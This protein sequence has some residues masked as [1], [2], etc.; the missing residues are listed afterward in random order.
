MMQSDADTDTEERNSDLDV[1][2]G[3][4]E[5]VDLDDSSDV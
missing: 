1:V 3:E 5:M 4:D 2:S